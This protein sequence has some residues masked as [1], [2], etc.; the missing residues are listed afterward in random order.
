MWRRCCLDSLPRTR[1]PRLSRRKKPSPCFESSKRMQVTLVAHYGHKH[2]A[3]S[4]LVRD[5][6]AKLLDL[7]G[8][9]FLP[10]EPEQVHGTVI[11]LEGCRLGQIL[12]NENSGLPMNLGKLVEFLRGPRL[13][14]IRVQVGGYQSSG[15]YPFRSRNAHP[16]LRSF[17]IQGDIAVAMGWPIQ[18]T[19]FANS[20]DQLRRGFQEFGVRHKWHRTDVEIDNDFFF[21]LGTIDRGVT[22]PAALKSSTGMIRSELSSHGKTLVEISRDTLRLVGYSNPQLPRATSCSYG[23]D[24]PDLVAKLERL[25][26]HCR[27]GLQTVGELQ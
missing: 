5:V 23:L 10:Y 19:E 8:P 6:Q 25:Y 24:E 15:E 27:S 26:P 3:L 7:F 21:V 18:G 13:K 1:F 11:G 2:Q 16:Y 20:L 9:P 12:R 22:D 4:V 14:P 17:S